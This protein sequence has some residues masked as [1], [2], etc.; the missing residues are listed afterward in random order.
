MFEYQGQLVKV[1][2]TAIEMVIFLPGRQPNLILLKISTM[3]RVSQGQ[4]LSRVKLY[5]QAGGA[6]STERQ[7]CRFMQLLSLHSRRNFRTKCWCQIL[8]FFLT[9]VPTQ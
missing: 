5:Q 1:K 9:R 6:I 8:L 7:S 2:V 4:G 3:S